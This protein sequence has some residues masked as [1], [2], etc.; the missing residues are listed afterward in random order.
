MSGLELVPFV[1]EGLGNSSYLLHVGQGR[2]ALVDPDRTIERYM[3]ALEDREWLLVAVFETHLHADF[4]SGS[5][6]AS[7]ATGATLHLPSAGAAKFEH[8]GLAPGDRVELGEVEIEAIA[9]PGHTPEHLSYVVRSDD[10]PPM[11]FSGGALIV[12]GAARTDLIAPEMTESLTRA[13][14]RTLRDAFAELPDETGLFPTHG[15]GS[16][17]SVAR[18]G[19]RSSTLGEER[20]SNPLLATQDE[21]MFVHSFPSTFPAVPAY[22]SRMR[23]LNQAGPR[24]RDTIDPP[25]PL[26]V[27]SSERAMREG[28]LLIDVRSR[29]RYGRAHVHGS[30]SIPFRDVFALWLGWLAPADTTLLFVADGMDLDQV[31]D[32]CLLVGYERFAGYLD[33]GIASWTAAGKAVSTIEVVDPRRAARALEGGAVP[34]DVREPDE[35]DRGHIGDAVHIPLG[36]LEGG[37]GDLP[38]GKPVLAY[39]G[40]GDR[41]STAASILERAGVSPVLNLDGGFDAWEGRGPG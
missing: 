40:G 30:L 21:E 16:F 1:H 25:R 28:A 7:Q 32:E 36:F 11:L 35:F 2:A 22:F 14:F 9:S 12:G 33:G 15:G 38:V 8:R 19:D 39:C 18:D 13:E 10:E 23:A 41:A 6:E 37:I 4:L 17:C 24:L 5:L 31:M 20:R 3:E 27:G 29:E 26:S 34:L